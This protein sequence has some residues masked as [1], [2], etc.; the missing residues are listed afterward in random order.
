MPEAEVE[1]VEVEAVEVGEPAATTPVSALV[2]PFSLPPDL[3][4]IRRRW[5]YAALEGVGPHV[6]ILFPFLPCAELGPPARAELA[7]MARAV[8]VFTVR[9]ERVRRFPDVVWLEPEPAD[10]FA[11]LT[12]AV[13]GRWPDHP[14]YGGVHE[15]VIPHLTVVESEVAA[16]DDVEAIARRATPL[17]RR[18]ERLELW[19][20]DAAGR[21]RTRWRLPLGVRR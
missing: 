8:P 3:A 10:P 13:A 2:V 20:R 21:W 6:T 16:L 14:P 11:T 18:A 1:S 5:D 17:E 9:F 12:A 7:A 19:C 15:T 4:A